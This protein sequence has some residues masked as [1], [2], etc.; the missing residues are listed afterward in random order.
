MTGDAPTWYNA[1]EVIMALLFTLGLAAGCGLLAKAW[2]KRAGRMPL[3]RRTSSASSRTMTIAETLT[4]DM[5]TRL[6]AVDINGAHQ[7]LVLTNGAP[8]IVLPVT[9][10]EEASCRRVG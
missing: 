2:H 6:I 10:S 4:L 9:T 1:L 3:I 8:P 7:Y 5:R